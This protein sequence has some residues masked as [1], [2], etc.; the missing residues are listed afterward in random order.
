[1]K[2]Q[3]VPS[4]GRLAGEQPGSSRGAVVS[5][6][7]RSAQIARRPLP[8]LAADC[9]ARATSRERTSKISMIDIVEPATKVSTK[10]P[11]VSRSSLFLISPARCF[12][13]GLH[14][15]S[16]APRSKYGLGG[17]T[18]NKSC[19]ACWRNVWLG[20]NARTTHAT[21]NSAIFAAARSASTTGALLRAT[22]WRH[23]TRC[24]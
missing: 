1:M 12:E 18:T 17:I 23:Y 8:P 4:G 2:G 9:F 20:F 6:V 22:V 15:T 16:I 13:D 11:R 21:G 5:R 24:V 3:D 14:S 19:K 10:G 7:W